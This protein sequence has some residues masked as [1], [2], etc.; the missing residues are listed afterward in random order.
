MSMWYLG[1]I[2]VAYPF[3]AY[4]V[5]RLYLRWENRAVKIRRMINNQNETLEH[6]CC[7]S[8]AGCDMRKSEMW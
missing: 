8:V 6:R 4:V 7:Y 5:Y 2:V 1:A 3:V